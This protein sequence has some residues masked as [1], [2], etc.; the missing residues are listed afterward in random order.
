[1]IS[2]ATQEPDLKK[3]R[4]QL[5]ALQKDLDDETLYD[6]ETHAR[7][8]GVRD[9]VEMTLQEIDADDLNNDDRDTL[10]SDNLREVAAELEAENPGVARTIRATLRTL[11]NA[12]L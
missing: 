12:G 8:Q 6:V 9:D 3:I 4:K 1:M 2:M 11:V 5:E 10:L 7:L